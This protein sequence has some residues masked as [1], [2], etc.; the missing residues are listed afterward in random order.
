MNFVLRN[1]FRNFSI[2]MY[3]DEKAEHGGDFIAP[4]NLIT[5]VNSNMKIYQCYNLSGVKIILEQN[6]P[7]VNI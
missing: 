1:E 5:L 4:G 3:L 6:S 7:D 2:C